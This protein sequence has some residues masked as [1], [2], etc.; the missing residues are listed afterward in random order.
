G[1]T[2]ARGRLPEENRP[3]ILCKTSCGSASALRALLPARFSALPHLLVGPP[4]ERH[5]TGRHRNQSSLSGVGSPT[6]W[7]SSAEPRRCSLPSL[8]PCSPPSSSCTPSSN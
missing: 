4:P 1:G 2:T 8:A 6:P 5:R 7:T 3:L